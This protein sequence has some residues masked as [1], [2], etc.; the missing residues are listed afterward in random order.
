MLG[1]ISL[2]NRMLNRRVERRSM[3]LL[4]EQVAHAGA[5][6]KLE[7]RTLLAMELH[8]TLA[9]DLTGIALQIDAAQ[10]AAEESPAA[11][12]PYLETVR[13]KMQSCRESLRN[14]LW[15]L[16]NGAFEEKDL[17]EAIRKT[18][19]PHIDTAQAKFDLDIP[20]RKLSDNTIH[21]VLCIM[22]ELAV[23]AVR[24]GKART[25]SISGT[26]D[27]SGL[28]FKVVDDGI[29]FDPATRPGAHEGHFGLQG[30]SERVRRLG[31]T[32]EIAS[33]P[34]RGTVATLRNLTP[35]TTL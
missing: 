13:R 25:I 5:N 28:S 17:S 14:C 27:R 11:A 29:G 16:R 21:A 9:Q 6:L 34:G 26:L 23:N 7:E 22:R 19:A 8:D 1:G 4:K 2:W 10:M 12:L 15:D 24:H 18:I 30:V 32:F 3:E 35:E 33:N 20:C 31:G